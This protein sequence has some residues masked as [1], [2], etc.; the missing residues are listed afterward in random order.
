MGAGSSEEMS[1]APQIQS[2]G[3][4]KIKPQDHVWR[5]PIYILEENNPVC[6][7]ITFADCGVNVF[8]F[9]YFG[10]KQCITSSW[11]L[12]SLNVKRLCCAGITGPS[13]GRFIIEVFKA[14]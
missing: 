4:K 1:Q 5:C 3:M 10:H 11:S 12:M 8:S 7:K 13:L 9:M 6:E 2:S 14:K